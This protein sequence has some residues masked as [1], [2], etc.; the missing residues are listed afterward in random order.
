MERRPAASASIT[1]AACAAVLL[2]GLASTLVAAE[3]RLALDALGDLVG[4]ADTEELLGRIFQ[5]FC[6][7]K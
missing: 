2:G 4:T 7:G 1:R 6:I 3:L 5:R